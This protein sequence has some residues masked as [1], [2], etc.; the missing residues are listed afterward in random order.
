MSH[1][2]TSGDR[3]GLVRLTGL[4]CH[5]NPRM[6]WP[7]PVSCRWRPGVYGS[8]RTVVRRDGATFKGEI[9]TMRKIQMATAMALVTLAACGKTQEVAKA[10]TAD[11]TGMMA[12]APM[13]MQGMQMIPTMG[14][15]LDSLGAMAPAQMTTMMPAHL[16]LA[17]QMMDAMGADMRGRNITVDARWPALA[18]SVRQDLTALPGLSGGALQARMQDHIGRMRRM[19]TLHEGMMHM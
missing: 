3:T 19:M 15:H 10:P 16:A 7:F 18:D 8:L 4:A 12:G 2:H 9:L 11:S 17:S 6:E 5:L 1:R 14:A 13:A